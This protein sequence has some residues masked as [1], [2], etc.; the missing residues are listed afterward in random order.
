MRSLL[1]TYQVRNIASVT[2]LGG[3]KSDL[4]AVAILVQAVDDEHHLQPQTNTIRHTKNDTED[5]SKCH[6][7]K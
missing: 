5:R 3:N 1:S 2:C 6:L 7:L 4:L